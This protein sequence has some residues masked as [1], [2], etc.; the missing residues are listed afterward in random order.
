M[1]LWA[2]R[3][4]EGMSLHEL[5]RCTGVSPHALSEAD[6]AVAPGGGRAAPVQAAR[7]R[8]KANP[9]SPAP[10]RAKL[11]GSGTGVTAA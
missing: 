7:R 11:A 6:A 8:T 5:L 3:G 10:S 2:E 1:R 9:A 4:L